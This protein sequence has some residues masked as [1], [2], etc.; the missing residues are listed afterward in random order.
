MLTVF[1]TTLQKAQLQ[2]LMGYCGKYSNR[3]NKSKNNLEQKDK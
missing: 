1:L 3:T 2:T